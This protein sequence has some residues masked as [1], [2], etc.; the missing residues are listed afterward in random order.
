MA[1]L[2]YARISKINYEKGMA[3]IVIEEHENQ[4]VNDVPFLAGYYEMPKVKERVAV[5]LEYTQGDIDKGVILG[6][7]YSAEKEPNKSGKGIF[8]KR[9]QDGTNIVYDESSKTM[10]IS[11]KCVKVKELNAGSVKTKE[12]NADSAKISSLDAPCNCKE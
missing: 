10:E 12:L 9:F 2:Y 7:I 5:L 3:D 8:E 4:V 11:A 6:P 1:K